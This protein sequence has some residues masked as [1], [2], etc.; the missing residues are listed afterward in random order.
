[1]KEKTMSEMLRDIDARK[2]LIKANG[3]L[4]PRSHL[5]YDRLA[6]G[7]R[8]AAYRKAHKVRQK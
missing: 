1:M 2:A 7:G 8:A 3:G 5:Y 6:E 4:Y